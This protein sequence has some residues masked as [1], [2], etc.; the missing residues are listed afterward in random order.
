MTAS[1]HDLQE[2]LHQAWSLPDGPAR[3]A[4]LDTVFR[5]ADAA[6]NVEFAFRARM[7]SMSGF[8]HGGDPTRLFLAFSWCLA[9]FDKQPEVAHQHDARSLLWNFKWVVWSLPQFPEIPLERTAAVLDDMERRYLLGGHS[10]HAVYQHRWLVAHHVGDF[11]AAQEWYDRLLTAPRD[12]LSDCGACV[13]SGQVRHLVSLG[14]YEE[15]NT[16]G[17][18]YK[19]G[20]CTE[21]PQW[22]LAELLPAM[23]HT[24][25]LDDAVDAFRRGYALVRNDRHHLDNIGRYLHFCGLTGNETHG[26]ELVER[27][28]GWL[29]RPSSPYAAMEFASAAAQ[30]LGRLRAA[31]HGDLVVRR[32]LDDGRRE[33]TSVARL[34][35]ELVA[36]ARELAARFDARNGNTHQSARVEARMAAEPVVDRLP[37]TVLAGRAAADQGNPLRKTL[38]RLLERLA[39]ELAAGDETGAARTRF[40]VAR[41]LHEGS[42]DWQD[43]VEAAE[44]ALRSLAGAG[45]TDLTLS[46]RYLLWQLYSGRIYQHCAEVAEQLAALVAAERLPAEVP[47]VEVLLEGAADR[48]PA[49]E[50]V[51]WLIEAADRHR[52]RAVDGSQAGDEDPIAGEFRTLRKALVRLSGQPAGE[53]GLAVLAR[54]DGLLP[55]GQTNGLLPA[56]PGTSAED[57]VILHQ[58]AA[59]VLAGADRFD[60][61]MSRLD[62]AVALLGDLSD[63][64]QAAE[65]RGSR[66]RLLLHAGRPAEAEDEARA[67]IGA[68]PD[69]WAGPILLVKALRAQD[70]Q[71]EAARV[72]T[73]HDL[74]EEDLDYDDE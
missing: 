36:H 58:A 33:E 66:A 63:P 70:R 41:T 74:D 27:H 8:H 61:A 52:I 31:G 62:Q 54:I 44:E 19:R 2:M 14:R 65:I 39:G 55:A 26:L 64:E 21:Q 34:H 46:C 53:L 10:L 16:V 37:L 47:A 15:A 68:D 18:P 59:K 42:G 20:G 38:D 50:A 12:S 28:L 71:D 45:L 49:S 3:F 35:D 13:P 5:H 7:N 1:E 73:D 25:R 11:A 23:L 56:A 4:A 24:G 30:I 22:M 60:E 67:A 32:R 40:E 51:D 9:T 69:S 17:E 6:G 29:E 57:L 43:A 72:M 48:T